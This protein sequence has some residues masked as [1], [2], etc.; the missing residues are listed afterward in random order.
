MRRIIRVLFTSFVLLIVIIVGLYFVFPLFYERIPKV[1]NKEESTYKT[2]V[3]QPIDES[4]TVIYEMDS[5]IL[6]FEYY[7]FKEMLTDRVNR[8]TGEDDLLNYINEQS[9]VSGEIVLN[10]VEKDLS[11]YLFEDLLDEGRVKI[12]DKVADKYVQEIQIEEQNIY[13]GPLCGSGYKYYRTKPD[14]KFILSVMLWIS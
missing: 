6:T 14:Y 9:T 3:L 11:P 8:G 1:G 7:E 2:I 10:E 13:C 4:K 5:L 12:Y